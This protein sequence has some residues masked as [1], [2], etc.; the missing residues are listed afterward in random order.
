MMYQHYRVMLLAV[1]AL[2]SGCVTI[3]E[4]IQGNSPQPYQNLAQ[5]S[6]SPAQYK[7]QEARF[8][9]K[10]INVTNLAGKTRLE[11]ATLPLDE[12]ARPQLESKSPGR[13][14]ADIDGFTEPTDLMNQMITVVGSIKG[15]EKGKIGQA[16]YCFTV[17]KITGYQRWR[18][19]QTI[20]DSP[21][22][23][24]YTAQ[25]ERDYHSGPF[26]FSSEYPRIETILT[27]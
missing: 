19:M 26:T 16:D 11:I 3:P 12:A 5:I 17:L 18:I 23:Y 20:V 2:L 27:K 4:H 24:H 22:P 13:I 7:G 9:G 8:G 10:V 25:Y 21:R 14:Y 6:Y 1:T 15:S